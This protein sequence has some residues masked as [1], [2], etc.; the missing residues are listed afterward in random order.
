MS[1]KADTIPPAL[2]PEQERETAAAAVV[3]PHMANILAAAGRFRAPLPPREAPVPGYLAEHVRLEQL[4]RQL[5]A[6]RDP[7]KRQQI[8][9]EMDRRPLP[10]ALDLSARGDPSLP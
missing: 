5:Q 7:E 10:A 6:E 9:E 2:T 3:G 1:R 8:K 4:R